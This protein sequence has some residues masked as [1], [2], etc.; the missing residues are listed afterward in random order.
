MANTGSLTGSHSEM[1]LAKMGISEKY[2]EQNFMAHKVSYLSA[3]L[4]GNKERKMWKNNTFTT[5]VH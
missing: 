3:E 1:F 4:Q 2:F 5:N